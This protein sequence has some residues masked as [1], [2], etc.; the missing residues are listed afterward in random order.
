MNNKILSGI[1]PLLGAV[2]VAVSSLLWTQGFLQ[3]PM[4]RPELAEQRTFTEKYLQDNAPDLQAE[5]SLAEAY[6]TRYRDVKVDRHF[7]INGP[8]GI[9]GA[10]AHYEQHGKRE[11]RVF[12]PIHI[13]DDLQR[14]ER[15]AEIYWRR[16]PEIEQSSSWGRNSQLGI[17]G[18]RDHY[19][20]HGRHSGLRW[21]EE[22]TPGK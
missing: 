21:A 6:W 2:V 14:E 16:Y 15:L 5:R 1:R 8:S 20:Y 18:P 11:G 7:G 10:R 4:I 3:S 19:L 13:P 9:F 17:L 22:T 12:G